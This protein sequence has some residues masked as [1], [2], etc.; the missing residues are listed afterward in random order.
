MLRARLLTR[1]HAGC[2]G[3]LSS[4]PSAERGPLLLH[5]HVH[6]PRAKVL[7]MAATHAHSR[8]DQD[9]GGGAVAEGDQDRG[10]C[11]A[12]VHVAVLTHKMAA[13]WA[14]FPDQPQATWSPSGDHAA[15]RIRDGDRLASRAHGIRTDGLVG[16]EW[17]PIASNDLAPRPNHHQIGLERGAKPWTEDRDD[18]LTTILRLEPDRVGLISIDPEA[19]RWQAD[20]GTD[21]ALE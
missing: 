16:I 12:T 17:R 9:E 20:T 18:R 2:V 13:E 6:P 15:S 1:G 8:A 5:D 3:S 7:A 21:V 19:Q 10:R 14:I 4:A 11:F